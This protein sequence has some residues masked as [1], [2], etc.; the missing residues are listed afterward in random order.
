[1]IVPENAVLK[2]VKVIPY[3]GDFMIA[4]TFDNGKTVSE[5]NAMFKAGIDLGVDNTA[6]LVINDGNS[7]NKD[8]GQ[9]IKEQE[10]LHG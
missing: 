4:V 1:M 10:I 3:C 2:E 7:E 6:A 8:A 9:H 5:R